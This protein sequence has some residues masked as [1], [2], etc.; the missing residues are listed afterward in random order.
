MSTH[1]PRRIDRRTAEHLL[2]QAPMGIRNAPMG[3]R[4]AHPPLAALLTAAAMP[5]RPDEL[6]REQASVAAFRTAQLTQAPRP[7]R[8][9]VVKTVVMKVLTVKAV[10]VLAA[11]T[12]GGVALAASTG[13]LPNPLAKPARVTSSGLS[14]AP[15]GPEQSRGEQNRGEHPNS[16]KG[17]KPS[18][19][20]DA[21][22]APMPLLV[23]LCQAYSTGNK[24][25]HGKALDYP[26]FTA[27]T[28]TAGGKDKVDRFCQALLAAQTPAA[29]DAQQ[30]G[31]HGEDRHGGRH[32]E[33]DHADDP[34]NHTSAQ[35]SRSPER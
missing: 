17:P 23:G 5:G 26:A 12:A 9:S 15:P 35:P 32:D 19:S 33:N 34:A 27:L 31:R 25:E 16:S 7:R 4:N 3:L 13:T 8:L 24:T 18:E 6:A 10:A 11:T 2:G 22:K 20:P 14:A 28:T 29:S 30:G 1:N 21:S